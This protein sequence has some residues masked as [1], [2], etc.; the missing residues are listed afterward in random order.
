MP[1]L[2]GN[3]LFGGNMVVGAS[4][5]MRGYY[6]VM[7]LAGMQ[8]REIMIQNAAR[9]WNVP[10][11]EL[12]TEPHHVVHRASG[13]R[14]NY[15]EIAGFAEVPAGMPQITRDRLKPPSQFRLI[16]KDLPR[17]A[18]PDKVTCRRKES[19]CA[20]GEL[21]ARGCAPSTARAVEQMK[22]KRARSPR[23]EIVRRPYGSAWSGQLPAA[24][25]RKRRSSN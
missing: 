16:G 8:A 12:T 1:K 4:R 13:R 5:T 24:L 23:E 21:Y 25:K 19:T 10:A 9:R 3:P 15:G 6:E 2:Y 17:I 11:S 18:C 22:A 7:R 20:D 14:M